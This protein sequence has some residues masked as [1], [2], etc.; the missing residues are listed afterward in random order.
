[1]TPLNTWLD[2]PKIISRICCWTVRIIMIR[3]VIL[4]VTSYTTHYLLRLK[5]FNIVNEHKVCNQQQAAG[6]VHRHSNTNWSHLSNLQYVDQTHKFSDPTKEK[7]MGWPYR[8]VKRD[9]GMNFWTDLLNQEH[10]IFIF[11]LPVSIFRTSWGI[12]LKFL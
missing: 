10:T 7:Y 4:L 12:Y 1:M 11:L 9:I 5:P 2:R 3:T 6:K 8:L